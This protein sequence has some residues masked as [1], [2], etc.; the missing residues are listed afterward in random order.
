MTTPDQ[1]P[2]ER[3]VSSYPPESDAIAAFA[4]LA[5]EFCA[6][7]DGRE[8]LGR[9]GLLRAVHIRLAPLY[10]AALALP[11]VEAMDDGLEE[12]DGDEDQED[13]DV[14]ALLEGSG[15]DRLGNE[16]WMALY[17][18]LDALI[19]EGGLYAE[20]FDP[21]AQPPEEPVTGSLADDVA[22]IYRDLADGLTKWR[23][24][25]VAAAWWEWRFGFTIHWGEHAVSALRALHALA[26]EGT[27][28]FPSSTQ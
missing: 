13:V 23:R 28:G 14:A 27:R 3:T 20:V 12:S 26:A 15:K 17:R 24:G 2:A 16:Q 5:E 25:E 22:D 9:D 6:L 19:G 11:G 21:W 10:A 4:R 7:V 18:S 1:G 8:A